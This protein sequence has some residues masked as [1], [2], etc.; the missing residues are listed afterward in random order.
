MTSIANHTAID[1]PA[2]RHGGTSTRR[3]IDSPA[4]KEPDAIG[5][6][7]IA[8]TR[9]DDDG[10][11]RRHLGGS[12][13]RSGPIQGKTSWAA[14]VPIAPQ[15]PKG[16]RS[17]TAGVAET[18]PASIESVTKRTLPSAIATCAPPGWRLDAEFMATPISRPV[19]QLGELGGKMVWNVVNT[20]CI[21]AQMWPRPHLKSNTSTVG[22]K[23]AGRSGST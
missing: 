5:F 9:R 16:L 4:G 13:F 3:H 14:R 18:S 8:F 21:A 19:E 12:N 2:H 1:S 6:D 11:V 23:N 17:P 22:A 7:P 20:G 10:D 15:T